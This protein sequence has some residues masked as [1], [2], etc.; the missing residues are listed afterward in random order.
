M[1]FGEERRKGKR[2]KGKWK[3]KIPKKDGKENGP[4]E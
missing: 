4:D 3:F 2:R 1:K